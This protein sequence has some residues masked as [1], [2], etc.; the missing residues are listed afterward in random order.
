MVTGESIASSVV[1][2]HSFFLPQLCLLFMMLIRGLF[3]ILVVFHPPQNRVCYLDSVAL[4]AYILDYAS[5][6]PR[7]GVIRPSQAL[8]STAAPTTGLEAVSS[9]FQA[10]ISEEGDCRVVCGL[11]L[12]ADGGGVGSSRRRFDYGGDWG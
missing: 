1:P 4:S 2:G 7:L 12:A 8:R 10:P 5:A 6:S 11:V 3:L 9:N